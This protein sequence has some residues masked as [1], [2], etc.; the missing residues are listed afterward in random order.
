MNR[1]VYGLGDMY[2]PRMRLCRK[3]SGSSGKTLTVGQRLQ[4]LLSRLPC[5]LLR[6]E[7]C[8]QRGQEDADMRDRKSTWDRRKRCNAYSRFC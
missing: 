6:S 3:R 2:T 5:D 4:V 1:K 8:Q 7:T